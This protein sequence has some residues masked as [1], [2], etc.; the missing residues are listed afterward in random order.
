MNAA[1]AAP[2]GVKSGDLVKATSRRGEITL[3]AWVNERSAPGMCWA[4]FHFVEA[5]A[6]A[7]TIDAFDPV[8]ETAE[9]KVC[10]IR[11]EKVQDGETVME[12]LHRQA[13]P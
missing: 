9:Y 12:D 2:L 1:D 7:L 4:A 13:R 11:V 3:R 10:A 8:T 6:N 5:C